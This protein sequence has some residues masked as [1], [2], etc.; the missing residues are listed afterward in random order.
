MADARRHS[1][2]F[3]YLPLDFV[4]RVSVD[5]KIASKRIYYIPLFHRSAGFNNV[6]DWSGSHVDHQ[7]A[8]RRAE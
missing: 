6:A 2:S 3:Q 4:A 8:A 7:P 5:S 1:A